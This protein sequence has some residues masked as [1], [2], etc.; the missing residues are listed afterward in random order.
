[1]IFFENIFLSFLEELKIPKRTKHDNCLRNKPLLK[2]AFRRVCKS[3]NRY[4]SQKKI[5]TR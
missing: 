3:R 4:R 2:S 1:M 5:L